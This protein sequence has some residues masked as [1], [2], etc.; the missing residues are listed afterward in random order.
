[1]EAHKRFHHG[2]VVVHGNGSEFILF[3]ITW[4]FPLS[5]L[6]EGAI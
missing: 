5:F 2:E 3:K 1:M 6:C 4:K